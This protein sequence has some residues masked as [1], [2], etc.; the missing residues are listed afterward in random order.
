M[1]SRPAS[2]ASS[3]SAADPSVAP[4]RARVPVSTSAISR[5]VG[6]PPKAQPITDP[7]QPLPVAFSVGDLQRVEAIECDR[8]QS[9][10]TYPWRVGLRQRTGD[11]LKEG[12]HRRR[13][14]PAT[15]ITQC[16]LRWLDHRSPRQP[17]GQLLPDTRVSQ[18]WEHSQRN[19]E[20]HSDARR[21]RPESA[22]HRPGLRQHII[23][24]LERQVL[25]QLTEVA[26]GIHA[27]SNANHMG[28]H[29]S[30]RLSRQRNPWQR[31]DRDGL[32]RFTRGSAALTVDTPLALDPS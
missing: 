29:G 22:L 28:E 13:P 7:A 6:Y 5:S 3:R 16:F 19:N 11:D 31:E 2:D 14:Q 26:W 18:A 21:Q 20:I 15:Q 10:K 25:G 32:T 4:R 9:P 23:N 12:L 24:Q 17:D 30:G 27:V 8:A 1:S